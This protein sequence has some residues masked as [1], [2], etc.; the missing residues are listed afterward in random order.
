MIIY[1]ISASKLDGPSLYRLT[2]VGLST[3]VVHPLFQFG[4]LLVVCRSKNRRTSPSVFEILPGV[5]GREDGLDQ[6]TALKDLNVTPLHHLP[7]VHSDG[8]YGA[9]RKTSLHPP[10]QVLFSEAVWPTWNGKDA[11]HKEFLNR[12]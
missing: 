1:V 11:A 2:T 6:P 4:H 7:S 8:D 10:D 5:S 9:I 12:K 3:E